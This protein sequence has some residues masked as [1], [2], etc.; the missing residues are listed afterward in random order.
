MTQPEH[1]GHGSMVVM[2]DDLWAPVVGR[3]FGYDPEDD[4][5]LV[6]WSDLT[7]GATWERFESLELWGAGQ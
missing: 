3:T 4:T 1:F 6:L 7:L 5:Y 2:V